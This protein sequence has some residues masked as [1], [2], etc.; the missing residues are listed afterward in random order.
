MSIVITID[1]PVGVGKSTVAKVLAMRLGYTYL[2]TGAM[3]R[4]LSLKVLRLG[5]DL[6][7]EGKVNDLLNNTFIDFLEGKVVLDGE[8]VT[9]EIRTPEVERIVSAVASIPQVRMFIV[10]LERE[11]AKKQNIVVE[12]RDSGSV[13]FPEAKYKFYLDASI[14]ERTR[15]RMNDEKY[16][17][18]GI[19][20][21]EMKRM[22]Q[23]RDVLDKTREHGPLVVPKDAKIIITDNLTVEEVV[24]I[25]V[26][27][28]EKTLYVD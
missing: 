24:E 20:F 14:E 6:S 7:D 16:K 23:E 12:G 5:I 3:Y 4:A 8:D 18:K 17:N 10:K 21:E 1:G 15:R 27:E 2:D 13:V 26:K 9:S 28:I 11:I 19:S 25:M 22:I